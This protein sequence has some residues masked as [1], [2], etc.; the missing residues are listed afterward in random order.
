MLLA[1]ALVPSVAAA[2]V[3][4]GTVVLREGDVPAG[5]VFPVT[6]IRAPFVEPDGTVA[7]NGE[8]GDG[9]EFVWRD[10]QVVFFS[11]DEMVEILGSAEVAMGTREPMF[12]RSTS[13]PLP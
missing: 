5:T 1:C 2:V 12:R 8:L 7:F 4:P 13:G 9:S 11:V 6:N 10:D 3:V